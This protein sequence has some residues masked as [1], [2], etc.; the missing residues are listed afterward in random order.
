MDRKKTAFLHDSI[1]AGCLYLYLRANSKIRKSLLSCLSPPSDTNDPRPPDSSSTASRRTKDLYP[2]FSNLF[3]LSMLS[4]APVILPLIRAFV[5]FLRT[6]QSCTS[7][8]RSLHIERCF[9]HGHH[10]CCSI[11]PPSLP[12]NLQHQQ[13]PPRTHSFL[14]FSYRHGR[15]R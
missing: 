1:N 12:Q 5:V 4:L 2:T 7:P 9:I 15:A 10:V 8:G 6:K 11:V 3:R 14:T 13:R